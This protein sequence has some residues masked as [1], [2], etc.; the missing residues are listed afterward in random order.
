MSPKPK[1]MT[2]G[3]FCAYSGLSRYQFMRMADQANLRIKA[4]GRFRLVDVR[5]AL[6]AI[7][8]LPEDK[9]EPQTLTAWRPSVMREEEAEAAE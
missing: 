4:L 7:Q 1:F 3:D 6:A 8:A 9:E 2:I 5:E